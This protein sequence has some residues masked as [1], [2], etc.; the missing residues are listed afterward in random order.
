MA[1]QLLIN[2]EEVDISQDETIANDYQIAPIGK[3]QTRSSN[4]SITFTVPKTSRNR[5]IFENPEI[6]NNSTNVPYSLQK[7]R[8]L[9]DG[10]DQKIRLAEVAKAGADYEVR[11]YGGN[12]DFFAL[13]KGL[14]L[15]DLDFGFY[16]NSVYH[17]L[18][19]IALVDYPASGIFFPVIDYFTDSPNSVIDDTNARYNVRYCFP[20]VTLKKVLQTIAENVG[21]TVEGDILTDPNFE[22]VFLG[23]TGNVDDPSEY[24][25]DGG[26]FTAT[27]NIG[28]GNGDVLRWSC[29]EALGLGGAVVKNGTRL[30]VREAGGS[31]DLLTAIVTSDVT[32]ATTPAVTLIG[33]TILSN[34]S[35]ISYNSGTFE[36]TETSAG[37]F[38]EFYLDVIAE[39]QATGNPDNGV[40]INHKFFGGGTLRFTAFG[41]GTQYGAFLDIRSFL[42]DM[43]QADVIKFIVQKFGQLLQVDGENSVI[44]FTAFNDIKDNIPNAKDWS[45]LLDLSEDPEVTFRLDNYG[46]LNTATYK[47]QEDPDVDGAILTPPVG[48]NGDFAISNETLKAEVKLFES[49]FTWTKPVAR[50]NTTQIAQ[51]KIIEDAAPDESFNDQNILETEKRILCRVTRSKTVTYHDDTGLTVGG[52]AV[53]TGYFIESGQSFNLGWTDNLLPTYSQDFIDILQ[54]VKILTAYFRLT[55]LEINQLNFFV[56]VY[57]DYFNAYFYISKIRQFKVT[58]NRSTAVELVKISTQ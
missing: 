5:A 3:I 10:M 54:R 46:Q 55:A 19:Y 22:S 21:F 8:L 26:F 39:N 25:T 1:L 13:I 36:F 42:P 43:N 18:D 12:I 30:R 56:P 48:T 40:S 49:P 51:I 45:D 4:K 38:Y 17:W 20:S 7:A 27:Q 50:F 11:L 32:A 33:W 37:N 58:D 52:V 6:V 47:D 53:V 15:A 57:V 34:T 16:K 31:V 14:K 28:L 29:D 41:L 2:D 44:R 9:S 24:Y 35:T 23:A